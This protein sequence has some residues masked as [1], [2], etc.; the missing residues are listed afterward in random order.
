VGT[1]HQSLGVGTSQ[2]RGMQV[3]GNR[4]A[5]S[6]VAGGANPHAG[7]DRGVGRVDVPAAGHAQERCPYSNATRGNVDVRLTVDGERMEQS[8]A[9]GP[10]GELIGN[11]P[12]DSTGG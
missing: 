12:R 4:Q 8:A 5:E 10:G 1:K 6:A 3:E 11:T 7:R 9:G 2:L